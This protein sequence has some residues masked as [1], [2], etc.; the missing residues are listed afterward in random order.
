MI[1]K[2][3]NT[4]PLKGLNE[5]LGARLYNPRTKRYTNSVKT[6]NDRTCLKAIKK[7]LPAVHIDKPIRCTY[8]IYTADKR[9]DRSNLYA[10]IEKSFLDALQLAKVIKNDGW[11]DVYD[12][13]FHTNI[14]KENPRVVVEIEVLGKEK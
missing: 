11:D 10:A 7:C 9:H 2:K 3:N 5:L 14:D 8:C 12:S 1:D 6:S 4:F 13:V